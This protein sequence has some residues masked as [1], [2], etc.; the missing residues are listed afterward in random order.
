MTC[1]IHWGRKAQEPPKLYVWDVWTRNAGQAGV[2]DHRERAIRHVH[3]ALRSSAAR[4]SGKVHH[5]ALA[6]DGTTTYIDLR[7]VGEAWRDETTG[8]IIWRAE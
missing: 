5:V 3:E 6:P 7:T 2:T 1:T 8:A 4:A